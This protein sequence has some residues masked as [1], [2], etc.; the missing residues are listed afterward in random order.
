MK[1]LEKIA[2]AAK[3]R[4]GGYGEQTFQEVCDEWVNFSSFL[5]RCTE[6]G[7]DDRYTNR[8]KYASIDIP[9]G[10]EDDLPH[11]PK[12]DSRVMVAAQYILLAGRTLADD[13]FNKPI[14]GFGPEQ[15][16]CWV[17]KL[18]EIS[19]QEG[20]NTSLALALEEARKYMVSLHPEIS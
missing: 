18:K 9:N 19:M 12:R 10:L 6:A 11:G 1:S 17:G 14:K 2:T 16:R 20:N 7:L 5:A 8:C 15:W 4:R 13:C 3:E